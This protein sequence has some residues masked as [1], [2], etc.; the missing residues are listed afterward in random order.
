[1]KKVCA[2]CGIEKLLKRQEDFLD[3]GWQIIQC[4]SRKHHYFCPKHDSKD[5]VA[6]L[7]FR[8]ANS[9]EDCET[10]DRLLDR[11]SKYVGESSEGRSRVLK[12]K[13][14]IGYTK[15]TICGNIYLEKQLIYVSAKD[16]ICLDCEINNG[17]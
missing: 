4:I 15:C 6:F 7:M 14:G 3:A 11:A 12:K 5:L 8:N 1:M 9:Y 13:L 10:K 17:G 2:L 16:R